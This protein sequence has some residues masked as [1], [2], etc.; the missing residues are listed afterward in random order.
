MNMVIKPCQPATSFSWHNSCH[1]L[2][3]WSHY[4]KIKAWDQKLSAHSF[5]LLIPQ[6]NSLLEIPTGK[7]SP[8]LW[9]ASFMLNL[10]NSFSDGMLWTLHCAPRF[11]AGKK[12]EGLHVKKITC[13]VYNLTYILWWF[14]LLGAKAF[15]LIKFTWN[16]RCSNQ[17]KLLW[18][19][20]FGL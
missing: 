7:S 11:P 20:L 16:K 2:R 1:I 8:L 12:T 19:F 5:G 4:L 15:W 3:F 10:A 13:S 14:G 9:V 18:V 6:S 17:A